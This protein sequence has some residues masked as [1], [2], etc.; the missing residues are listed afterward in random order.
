MNRFL[1]RIGYAWG[2]LFDGTG[3]PLYMGIGH[4]LVIGTIAVVLLAVLNVL[5]AV[6][7]Y[8]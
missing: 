5:D 3:M 7:R 1:F 4:V 6:F 8:W 2:H